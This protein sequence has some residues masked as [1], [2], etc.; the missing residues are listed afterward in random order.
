M[1]D[2]DCCNAIYVY[3]IYMRTYIIQHQI[4]Y[5]Y[6]I[7]LSFVVLP[8]RSSSDIFSKSKAES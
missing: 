1:V 2:I 5:H 3:N 4:V 8:A 6:R 7:Y